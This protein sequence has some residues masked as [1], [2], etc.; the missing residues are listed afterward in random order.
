MRTAFGE[1]DIKSNET[2][3]SESTFKYQSALNKFFEN[4]S[5]EM[6]MA[7][8]DKEARI[9]MMHSTLGNTFTESSTLRRRQF[10]LQEQKNKELLDH[11]L[12]DTLTECAYEAVPYDDVFKMANRE[13][14]L[15]KFSEF[16]ENAFKG[17]LISA[18][19]FS[20]NGSPY[21]RDLFNEHEKF[22]KELS[23][24]Y[25]DDLAR[26]MLKVFNEENQEKISEISDNVMDKVVKTVASEKKIAK[27][28]QDI[29]DVA[30]NEGWVPSVA[31]K[32]K[33]KPTLFR[34]ILMSC[35]KNLSEET[36]DIKN[37]DGE[38]VEQA[39]KVDQKVFGEAV[40]LYT[41]LETM[42]TCNLIDISTMNA[43]KLADYLLTV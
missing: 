27:Q 25:D 42:N 3:L 36:T 8:N 33:G 39:P 28:N 26:E 23:E 2:N 38:V 29:D 19:K 31:K 37:E 13:T 1:L 34:S 17:G 32:M 10:R 15:K 4:R 6:E 35:G 22:I 14:L 11:L 5:L 12:V 41:L 21:V 24:T 30:K 16:Y 7:R 43:N 9:D 20:E 40:A 18:K